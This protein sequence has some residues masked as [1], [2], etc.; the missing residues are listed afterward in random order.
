MQIIKKSRLIFL[1]LS[2][3]LIA[4]VACSKDKE[5]NE[6]SPDNTELNLAKNAEDQLLPPDADKADPN[7]SIKENS[8]K[9]PMEINTSNTDQPEEDKMSKSTDAN[10]EQT[11]EK[12]EDQ[13][14]NEDGWSFQTKRG[15]VATP[16]LHNDKIFF[17]SKDGTFYAVDINTHEA[18][19]TY[20]VGNPIHGKAAI[21]DNTVFFSCADVFYALDINTG[22]E[23]WVYDLE[24]D[25]TKTKR[26]DDWDYH[27]AT[28]VIDRGVVYFGCCTGGIRGFEAATGE[29]VWEFDVDTN[30]PVRS[31]PLIYEDVL[32]YGDWNGKYQ[33]VDIKTKQL[34]WRNE[35][36]G[37]FQ[38]SVAISDNILIIGGR[39]TRIHALDISSGN[40]LW[41][42][43]DPKGSWI[44][45]DPTIEDGI[46]YIPTSD[47]KLVYA[48]NLY[49]G[50]IVNTYPIYR[51]SFTKALITD[52]LMFISSGDAYASPGTGKI[53]VYQIDK[54]DA[55]L[56]E[57]AVPT[58]G[59][60][61]SPILADG[62]IY[63]G[64]LDGSLYAKKVK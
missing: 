36:N 26:K 12:V 17:G 6:V 27:D 60:F 19:W 62:M 2:L 53:E 34:I 31:T 22:N 10:V 45:G 32:Y 4:L 52:N 11:K 46:V 3:G 13:P 41:E 51:N 28:P 30:I 43:Q 38:S 35:Y 48:L 55:V 47:A 57:I 20:E 63:Y 25:S 37:S 24:Q 14:E 9:D 29:L 21:L 44:T 54:P 56:W 5:E 59:V 1:I 40:Q 49:D 61:T 42:Y 8:E 58:G 15:I 18:V 39:D 16:L 23:L 33:A 7:D 50:S 64:C